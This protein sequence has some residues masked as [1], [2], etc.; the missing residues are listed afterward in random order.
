MGPPSSA[1]T[2]VLC[3]LLWDKERKLVEGLQCPLTGLMAATG[4]SFADTPAPSLVQIG[5]SNFCSRATMSFCCQDLAYVH[6]D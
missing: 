4:V 1:E 2:H 6:S 3:H 5:N